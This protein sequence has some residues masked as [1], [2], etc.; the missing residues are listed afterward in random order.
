MA[1]DLS[2]QL[3]AG[4]RS[5]VYKLLLDNPKVNEFVSCPDMAHIALSSMLDAVGDGVTPA[6]TLTDLYSLTGERIEDQARLVFAQAV[7]PKFFE[8]IKERYL[9]S[10][11]KSYDQKMRQVRME[12][13]FRAMQDPLVEWD[14]WSYE[15]QVEVGAWACWIIQQTTQWFQEVQ[16][17]TDSQ[18]YPTTK[19]LVLSADGLKDRDAILEF[20]AK[21]AFTRF[22]MLVKPKDWSLHESGG[23]LLGGPGNTSKLIHGSLINTEPS[24]AAIAFLNN[25]QGQAFKINTWIL[26]FMRVLLETNT[27]I[28]TFVSYR[29]RTY[30]RPEFPDSVWEL[31]DDSEEKMRARQ[32]IAE[33]R[34]KEVELKNKAISPKQV[35]ELAEMFKHAH[36]FYIPWF[37]DT[38]LR[39]YPLV[40]KLSPQGSDFQKALLLFADGAEVTPE[41]R[42][43][44]E[45]VLLIAIGTTWGNKIDKES[46]A[47]RLEWARKH[48]ADNLERILKSPLSTTSKDLWTKAEEPFQHL[49]LL[50]EY[51]DIFV[52]GTSTTCAVPIGYDATCSGLQLL[53]SFVKDEATCKLVNVTP[54]I[55]PQDAYAAVARAAQ[56][57]LRDPAQW[58]T[59]KGRE[60]GEPHK[61]PVE[62]IDRKVAKKV[63][64]L[65]PYGGTY[66]TLKKH[67]AEATNDWELSTR[68]LHTLTKAL[69]AGMAIA[70]PGFSA[71]NKWFKEAAKAVMHQRKDSVSWQ[72]AAGSTIHQIYNKTQMKDIFTHALGVSRYKESITLDDGSEQVVA[73]NKQSRGQYTTLSFDTNHVNPRKHVTALAANWTHSQD[74]CVL[75]LAF[76]YFDKPFTTVHDC[77]YAPAPV[78][79]TA[80]KEVRK[81]F[82]KVTSWGA[83]HN[84]LSVNEVDLPL[85]PV[86]NADISQ[87]IYSEYLFS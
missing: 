61:I 9:T 86:G 21:N 31:P 85:P 87:A 74:A 41:N 42:E 72:T 16:T 52:A 27:E 53:G 73:L 32:I 75:Q 24:E 10:S 43:E 1:E 44:T 25:V 55:K 19:F 67:V 60:E 20:A 35:I 28:G 57:I 47:G 23:Y 33:A 29:K 70:V 45:E 38:R 6:T 58:R 49:A 26:D 22:P 34:S 82:V 15:E 12:H 3:R 59:L 50:K 14:S 81:S 65:I 40:T 17:R 63:V 8:F 48:V 2:F 79:R 54:S 66:D 4:T 68:D 56:D 30:I 64:M 77:V 71:L 80:V 51:H 78:I 62:K 7:Q 76:A 46:F 37:F 69:I 13:E 18:E 5:E 84:F 83:L 36:R 39:A 11:S